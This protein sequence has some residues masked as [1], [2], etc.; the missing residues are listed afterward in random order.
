MHVGNWKHSSMF[1]NHCESYR[2][3]III[4]FPFKKVVH[5][6]KAIR[7]WSNE[8]SSNRKNKRVPNLILLEFENS[9]NNVWKW[10]HAL[11]NITWT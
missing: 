8:C 11:I 10:K 1:E 2:H 6:V 5:N 4:M 3:I 9:K 7:F